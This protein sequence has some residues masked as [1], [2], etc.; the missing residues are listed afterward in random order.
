MGLLNLVLAIRKLW[1]ML[2]LPI[3]SDI[4]STFVE[5]GELTV[6]NLIACSLSLL[7][8]KNKHNKKKTLPSFCNLYFITSGK[9]FLVLTVFK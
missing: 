3:P 9:L 5:C 6:Y 4:L 1:N 7:L 2:L 8:T